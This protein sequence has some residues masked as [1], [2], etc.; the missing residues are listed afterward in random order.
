MESGRLTSCEG[1]RFRPRQL[2]QM[3]IKNANPLPLVLRC[4]AAGT[5]ALFCACP[6][7][8]V[9]DRPSKMM[10]R[11]EVGGHNARRSGLARQS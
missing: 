6:W 7:G 10:G 4:E 3:P 9:Y 11:D 8:G 2:E 1:C 5:A